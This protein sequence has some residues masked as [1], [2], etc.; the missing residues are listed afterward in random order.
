MR[1]PVV[2][3]LA[4]AIGLATVLGGWWS[5]PLAAA[6]VAVL[7][8][9]RR[10]RALRRPGRSIAGGTALA[11]ALAWAALLAFDATGARFGRVAELIGGLFGAPAAVVALAT[12]LL[13]ALLAWSA[14]ALVEE[15]VGRG[16]PSDGS[17]GR[18]EHGSASAPG[19]DR[20]L[21]GARPASVEAERSTPASRAAV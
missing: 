20:A 21:P 2:L 15:L 19:A 12:A 18:L 10:G 11:A 17:S 5:V 13:P 14:A 4:L 6:A 8:G 3:A 1:L 7:A 9:G 16:T